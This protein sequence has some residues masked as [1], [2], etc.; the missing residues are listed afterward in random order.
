MTGW[1]RGMR[2]Y[3][4]TYFTQCEI[5]YTKNLTYQGLVTRDEVKGIHSRT[6]CTV[7]NGPLKTGDRVVARPLFACKQKQRRSVRQL[8]PAAPLLPALRDGR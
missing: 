1:H 2:I 7:C 8:P 6:F 5:Y 4:R 3:F